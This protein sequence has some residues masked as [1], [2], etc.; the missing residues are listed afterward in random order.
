MKT[1]IYQRV[2][3]ERVRIFFIHAQGDTANLLKAALLAA[4]CL[5]QGGANWLAIGIWSALTVAAILAAFAVEQ[6]VKRSTLTLENCLSFKQQKIV[7]GVLV[8]LCFGMAGFLFPSNPPLV[9]ELFLFIIAIAIV[10][11]TILAFA[12]LPRYY[13]LVNAACLIPLGVHHL[14]QLITLHEVVYFLLICGSIIWQGTILRKANLV[15]G[16]SR[17][18]ITLQQHFYQ[19]LKQHRHDKVV[20]SHLAHHDA[21]TGLANRRY[22]EDVSQRSLKL[23]QRNH[24]QFALLN[25]DLNDFKPVNDQHGRAVGDELLQAVAARLRD[26]LRSSDF[27]ARTGGD[28]FMVLLERVADSAEAHALAFKLQH[29]LAQ[30][31]HLAEHSLRIGASIGGTSYPEDGTTLAKLLLLA[32]KNMYH[33]KRGFKAS[34]EPSSLNLEQMLHPK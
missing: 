22:F 28:E 34:K 9:Y 31:F 5:F 14:M 2:E 3:L 16:S 26:T 21:L 23:A 6:R 33:D 4:L 17:K 18:V 30:P 19:K 27:C 24:S 11:H 29:A 25:I 1:K 12:V 32:D 10:T 13:L 7:W 8:S 20:I 15:S